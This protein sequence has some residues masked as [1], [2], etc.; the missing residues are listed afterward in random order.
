MTYTD[1][2]IDAILSGFRGP[3]R[4]RYPELEGY[5]RDALYEDFYGGGGL[6][7]A[8]HM[9]R[10]MALKPGDIV[11]D[12]GCG[13]G[14]SSIFLA[15]HHGVKVIALDLWTPASYLNEKFTARGYRDQITPLHL[16]VTGPLPFA[17]DYFDAIFCMNSFSFYGGNQAF[18][19]H[20]LKYL[21]PGG[22]LC[23]GSEV[24]SHE[25][26]EEQLKNPPPVYAF[27]LPE[28]HQDVNVFEDDFVKQHTPGW[29]RALFEDSGLLDVTHCA[30]LEDADAIYE[31]LLRYEHQ[32]GIDPFDVQICLQ[33]MAWGREQ[34]PRK[35]LFVLSARRR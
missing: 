17:D 15:R 27:R 8:A 18:L 21:R 26:T 4:D 22:Q 23:I 25:F 10:Q 24:L 30:E 33:Q 16:D 2:E 13:K 9:L 11:L 35:S 14:S 7:L 19:Q 34:Q 12:L 32:N 5:E 28:P 3:D 29:W 31:E 1:E 6:Y 20:L